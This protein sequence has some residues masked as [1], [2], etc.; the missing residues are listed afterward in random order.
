MVYIQLQ[1]CF[2]TDLYA[3]SYWNARRNALRQRSQA[4]ATLRMQ[5]AKA[6]PDKAGSGGLDDTGARNG[7]PVVTDA[8]LAL[9]HAECAVESAVNGPGSLQDALQQGEELLNSSVTGEGSEDEAVRA[10][11]DVVAPGLLVGA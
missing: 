8:K 3:P 5:E 4:A 2:I 7:S 1:Q 9:Q 10:P 6:R 11:A